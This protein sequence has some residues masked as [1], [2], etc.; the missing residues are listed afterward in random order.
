MLKDATLIMISGWGHPASSLDP[1][2]QRIRDRASAGIGQT[3]TL[4]AAD[5]TLSEETPGGFLPGFLARLREASPPV[6]LAGWSLGALI[7]LEAAAELQERLTGLMLLSGTACFC[8]RPDY[9]FGVV[10]ARLKAMIAALRCDPAPVVRRFVEDLLGPG[11]PDA[12][13]RGQDILAT[14]SESLIAQLHYLREKDLRAKAAAVQ[15][16][17]LLLHGRQD[18]IIPIG[19]GEW[20]A[21]HCSSA[22]GV[23]WEDAGHDL[24]GQF[25]DRSA[26]VIADFLESLS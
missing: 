21:A 13:A 14:G 5:L 2:A 11:A 26:L 6:L 23:F 25:I 9:P 7:A 10:P 24:P 18:P 17:V 1:L 19:A 20:L 4:A 16:P 8:T 12:K 3:V 22:R 15:C